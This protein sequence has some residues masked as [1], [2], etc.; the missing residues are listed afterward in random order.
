MNTTIKIKIKTIG[1]LN[2]KTGKF[3]KTKSAWKRSMQTIQK[4]VR[5]IKLCVFLKL[6]ALEAKIQLAKR[7]LY[8]RH[9]FFKYSELMCAVRNLRTYK[10]S[11]P[12]WAMQFS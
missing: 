5:N 8:K 1:F 2:L 12:K 6:T 4:K 9:G 10:L 11:I 7:R 3:Y